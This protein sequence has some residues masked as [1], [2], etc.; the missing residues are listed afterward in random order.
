LN[1]EIKSKEKKYGPFFFVV[2]IGL[3]LQYPLGMCILD[4]LKKIVQSENIELSEKS[5]GYHGDFP[6]EN[7]NTRKKLFILQWNW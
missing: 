1:G 2:D 5:S 3:F 7:N 4:S 6:H